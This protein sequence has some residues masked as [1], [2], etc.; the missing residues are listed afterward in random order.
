MNSLT[1]EEYNLLKQELEKDPIWTQVVS[2]QIRN[3]Y[4]D[5]LHDDLAGDCFRKAFNTVKPKPKRTRRRKS[6]DD[7]K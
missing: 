5:D 7:N 4:W 1:I 3:L 6:V 2:E